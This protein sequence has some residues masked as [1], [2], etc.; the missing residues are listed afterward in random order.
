M[1]IISLIF[2]REFTSRIQKTSFIVMSIVGPLLIAAMLIVPLWLQKIEKNQIHTV[3]IIDETHILGETIKDFENY[4]FTIVTE[5]TVE[6]IRKDFENSGFDAV[7]FIP[8][9]IFA[10]NT[11]IIYSNVW[12]D[13]AL[14]AYVG[15]VLRRD[16]EYMAL[17]K[18][19]VSPETIKRVRTP[20]SIGVQKWTSDGE[21]IDEESSLTKKSIMAVAAAL[22]IYFFIFMYGVL[23]LRGVIEEKSNRVVEVI[24]SSVKPIQLM[25]GKILGICL[26]GLVQFVL[27]IALSFAIVTAAQKLIFPEIY[28]PTPLP[29]LAQTLESS[30]NAV[31]FTPNTVQYDYVI[32]LFQTLDGVNWGVMFAAF[33]FFFIVGYLLYGGIFAG[34][35]ALL[36]HDSDTQQ[37]IIPVSLPLIL[38]IVL[39]NSIIVN[40]TG[41]VAQWLSFIPF[42]AP[43]A[44]MARLPFGVPYWQVLLSVFTLLLS[45]VAS[46]FFAA[47]MYKSGLLMYGKKV[48]LST[49]FTIMKQK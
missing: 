23:V 1:N 29:E 32:D 36:D 5:V 28:N 25:V 2:K 19:N 39:L 35:G 12:I 40:P 30:T 44:M 8:G 24:V 20:V 27:W 43:I 49:I 14:K 33:F 15:Y 48:K 9:N 47:R 38:S 7:L 45:C 46:M 17:I 11:A 10:S 34:I 13:N 31:Q 22:M 26:V 37:F 3:A 21:Y 16:L 18:E 42:T 41:V 4:H 6:E